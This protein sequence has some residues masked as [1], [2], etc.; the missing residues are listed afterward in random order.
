VWYRIVAILARMCDQVC[1]TYSTLSCD[2]LQAH[3]ADCMC[4][5][6]KLWLHGSTY[7]SSADPAGSV[8]N[9]RNWVDRIKLNWIELN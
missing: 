1:L 7:C 8:A 5:T 4:K 9:G 3:I 2:S 6:F